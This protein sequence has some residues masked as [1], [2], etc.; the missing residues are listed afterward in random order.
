MEWDFGD[1]NT[2]YGKTIGLDFDGIDDVVAVND[3]WSLDIDRDIRIEVMM[4]TVEEKPTVMNI[5]FDESFAFNPKIIHVSNDT[6]AIVGEGQLKQEGI[7]HVVNITSDGTIIKNL[8]NNQLSFDPSW[9]QVPDIIKISE[10]S[11]YNIFAIVYWGKIGGGDHGFIK[12]IK[13][14]PNNASVYDTGIPH[15]SAGCWR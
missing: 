11:D 9:G 10:N 15:G 14:S 6:F 7:V 2:S 8:T 12:T 1:G 4:K 3:S 13:I 5:D